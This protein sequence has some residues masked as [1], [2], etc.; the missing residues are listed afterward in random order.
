MTNQLQIDSI[1]QTIDRIASST[2]FQGAKLLNGNFDFTVSGQ[3]PNVSD[4]QINAAKLGYGETRDVEVVITASAQHA[5]LFISTNGALDLTN[6]TSTFTFE[7]AG[8]KGSREFSFASGTSLDSMVEAINTFKDVTG[9][10]AAVSGVTGFSIKSVEYGS[11]EFVSFDVISQGGQAGSVVQLSANNENDLSGTSSTFANV[12][13]PIRDS[14]QDIGAIINGIAATSDGRTARI[15]TDFLDMEIEISAASG[16]AD[17]L[18][19]IS[20]LTIT[21]GGAKFNLGPSVDINNQVSIGLGNVAS[22][23]LGDINVGYLDDLG[24]GNSSNLVDGDLETAQKIVDAAISQVSSLRGKIGAFQSNVINSTINSL[25]VAL[26]NTSAAE[27]SIRD[28][29]FASETAAM[30]RAQILS[31]ASTNILSIANSQPQAA[32]QLL[33]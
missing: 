26:E 4:Y 1:L 32:L 14:G 3:D 30:T 31:S 23:K 7:I 18:Q 12:T 28:T 17:T 6:A 2:N 25:G 21:G 5:G 27:S 20:A 10:S 29:D 8:S 15:A 33:G 24:S 11:N 13:N 16:G 9:V 19:T 22:R